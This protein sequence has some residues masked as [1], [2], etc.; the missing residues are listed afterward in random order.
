MFDSTLKHAYWSDEEVALLR[1]IVEEYA[2]AE[3]QAMLWR[4]EARDV[5]DLEADEVLM[6]S[7]GGFWAGMPG[8]KAS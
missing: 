8:K 6:S 1:E 7:V 4:R 2:V 3:P 5:I